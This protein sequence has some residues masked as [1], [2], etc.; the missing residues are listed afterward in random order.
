MK[1]KIGDMVEIRSWEDMEN[2]YGL[3]EDGDIN[4]PGIFTKDMSDLCGK[5][6]D[7]VG[8]LDG[9]T[10]SVIEQMIDMAKDGDLSILA[11]KKIFY[12]LVDVPDNEIDDEESLIVYIEG[13]EDLLSGYPNCEYQ[14]RVIEQYLDTV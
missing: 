10:R 14:E 12:G 13:I 2:Q 11:F 1:Y 8:C 6:V 3:D 4:C 7:N 5:W 9:K